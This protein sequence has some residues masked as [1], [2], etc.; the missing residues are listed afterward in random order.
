ML[1][2]G[3]INYIDNTASFI[4]NTDVDSFK[5]LA[6]SIFLDD[7]TVETAA[8]LDELISNV[9]DSATGTMDYIQ[10]RDNLT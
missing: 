4:P 6:E 1:K 8:L 2:S 3:A 10:V 5:K 7:T 9:T